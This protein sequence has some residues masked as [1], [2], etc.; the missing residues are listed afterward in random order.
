MAL[1]NRKN[2]LI[3][4]VL[5]AAVIIVFILNRPESSSTEQSTDDAYTQADTTFV[6]PQISGI[7]TAV[8]VRDNQA[9]SE[10]MLLATIDDRDF[11][12]GVDSAKAR[13]E[14]AEATIAATKSKI[15]LQDSLI[16][17]AQAA[18]QA[19]IAQLSLAKANHERYRNLA[20]DGSG[21][22]QAAQQAEAQLGVQ[23]AAVEKSQASL[24]AANQ[25]K[26][27]LY[28][29]LN[30]EIAQLNEASATL[31][32]AELKLSYTKIYAPVDGT[33]LQ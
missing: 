5:I 17:Q 22:R 2:I 3:A 6:S 29:E 32:D 21:T 26:V 13:K 1:S 25:Q 10:G 15:I 23:S 11:I 19:D 27:I 33:I 8:K 18:L 9:V 12:V 31:S 4:L 24:Q 28:D 30:Q 20:A 16:R 14:N 7:I